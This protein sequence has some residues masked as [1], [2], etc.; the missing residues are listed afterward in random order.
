[1]PHRKNVPDVRLIPFPAMEKRAENGRCA[2]FSPP[3]HER[4]VNA[5]QNF[6]YAACIEH[7]LSMSN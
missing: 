1:M 3:Q 5:A 6:V 7:V 4:I 2:D